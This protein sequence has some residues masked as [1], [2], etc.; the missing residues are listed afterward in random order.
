MKIMIGRIRLQDTKRTIAIMSIYD[1]TFIKYAHVIF[2]LSGGSSS[3][4]KI[5]RGWNG[6]RSYVA[7]T[8]SS[9]FTECIQYSGGVHT[10][11]H[12][13]IVHNLG[14]VL[15]SQRQAEGSHRI[16]VVVVLL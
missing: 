16:R 12:N 8:A 9:A 6:S 1:K 7:R 13:G 4:R 14:V 15:C 5:C 3:Y 11:Y 10:R 2:L